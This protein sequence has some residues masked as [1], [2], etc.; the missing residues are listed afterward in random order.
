MTN[1]LA[2]DA[3]GQP[4]EVPAEVIGW[5][6]RR[7][8]G[9]GR[10]ELAHDRMGRPLVVPVSATFPELYR[11]A[12]P[13]RY[14]LDPIDATGHV[15]P[16][17]PIGC[18]GPMQAPETSPS[19]E[20]LEPRSEVPIGNTPVRPFVGYDDILCETIRANTRLAEMVISR[21]PAMMT[22]GA[23]LIAA[24]DGASLT[25][26]QP[27]PALPA[28]EPQAMEE[29][30][31]AAM[32]S[33]VDTLITQVV[34]GVVPIILAKLPGLLPGM[35]LG[36]LFDWSKAVPKAPAAA[37]ASPPPSEPSASPPPSGPSAS[38]PPSG[39]SASPPPSSPAPSPSR[40]APSGPS[41]RPSTPTPPQREAAASRLTSTDPASA[42]VTTSS[43]MTAD[44][45]APPDTSKPP[46]LTTAVP[47]PSDPG[48]PEVDE[49]A[50]KVH[51]MQVWAGLSPAEQARAEQ[52]IAALTPEERAQWVFELMAMSVP[53]ATARVRSVIR[54]HTPSGQTAGRS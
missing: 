22:A 2:I 23:G 41:M 53:D 32:P 37:S 47:A 49:T 7:V 42:M 13:G 4:F 38:P 45:G 30:P 15:C 14:K 26:R 40:P 52:L 8:E 54:P 24:A 29:A 51:L 17:V 27:L 48:A 3:E 10:P 9:R 36:A 50:M 28:P 43:A 12:G 5:R 21:V 20:G 11:A 31:Q 25:T 44:P 35:P 6:V 34:S 33:W 19:Q 1:E 18:T 16:D 39:P 46:T